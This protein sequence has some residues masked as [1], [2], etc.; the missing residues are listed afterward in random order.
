MSDLNKAGVKADGDKLRYDLIPVSAIEGLA[1]VLTMGA[2]KYTPGGWKTV[3][4][5]QERYYSALVRHLMAW[6]KG[7]KTD[8]ESGLNHMKHIMIN[9]AFLLEF[10][11]N[12][13]LIKDSGCDTAR[14][15]GLELPKGVFPTAEPCPD[16]GQKGVCICEDTRS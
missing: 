3:P 2:K 13:E 5:A 16:C 10:D 8:P 4:N 6:R 15:L 7:E 11:T 14:R 9:A 1:E 12:E